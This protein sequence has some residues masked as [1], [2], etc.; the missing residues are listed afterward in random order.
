MFSLSK[1]ALGKPLPLPPGTNA[2]WT[3][4]LVLLMCASLPVL[5][6]NRRKDAQGTVMCAETLYPKLKFQHAEHVF[7][8]K[9]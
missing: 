2:A 1:S 6:V 9:K 4:M 7:V 3:C 8:F 5:A